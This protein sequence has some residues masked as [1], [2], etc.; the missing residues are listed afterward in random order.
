MPAVGV[1]CRARGPVRDTAAA[2]AR[3]DAWAPLRSARLRAAASAHDGNVS[4]SDL[5][6]SVDSIEAA[7]ALPFDGADR[8]DA[9]RAQR[10]TI[11]FLERYPG[12]A[13]VLQKLKREA[14]SR[15]LPLVSSCGRAL[16]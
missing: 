16:Q 4:M 8:R 1:A 15:S 13:H 9:L 12:A 14:Y 2:M 10:R 3:V 6:V 11:E 7:R 5:T